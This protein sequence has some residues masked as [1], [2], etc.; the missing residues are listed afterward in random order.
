[1]FDDITCA[2][3]NKDNIMSIMRSVVVCL[4]VLLKNEHITGQLNALPQHIKDKSLNIKPEI[5]N[6][7]HAILFEDKLDDFRNEFIKSL[8]TADMVEEVD[9]F[10]ERLR[11]A[12]SL[13]TDVKSQT[14]AVIDALLAGK[15]WFV[16]WLW[17]LMENE[18]DYNDYIHDASEFL[19][20]E[21]STST[22]PNIPHS[23]SHHHGVHCYGNG[24]HHIH[25]RDEE[26]SS[27][28]TF[29]ADCHEV[30]ID[31][32]T[33]DASTE[34]PVHIKGSIKFTPK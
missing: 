26:T 11:M 24:S 28:V 19:I 2:E 34:V 1:M 32:K 22:I 8:R 9:I 10:D 25:H 21:H 33:D 23:S 18:H 29:S 30:V 5:I 12:R 27:I 3:A 16:N 20:S 14:N 17:S 15:Q 4:H 7:I 31:G 6:N 13:P